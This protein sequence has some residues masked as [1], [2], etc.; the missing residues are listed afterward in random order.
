MAWLHLAFDPLVKLLSGA[1]LFSP[2][3][4]QAN[5]HQDSVKPSVETGTAIEIGQ[6]SIGAQKSFLREVLCFLAITRE[7]ERDSV[8]LLFV[9]FHKFFERLVFPATGQ[10]D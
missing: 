3:V 7:I 8:G 4:V 5:I 10:I 6:M 1:A 2:F 9:P